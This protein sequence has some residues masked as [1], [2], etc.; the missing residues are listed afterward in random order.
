M[1]AGLVREAGYW[2]TTTCKS[3]PVFCLGLLLLFGIAS[4]DW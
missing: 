1:M 2:S 3:K 4:A